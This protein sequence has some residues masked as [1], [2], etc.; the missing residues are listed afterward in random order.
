LA[1]VGLDNSK[2]EC[3]ELINVL[4]LEGS[5]LQLGPVS[6][7]DVGMYMRAADV[8]ILPSRCDGWGAVISE[9]A[10]LGKALIAYSMVGAAHHMVIPGKNGFRAVSGDAD[11]FAECLQRY[12]ADPNLADVHGH[13][14]LSIYDEY[15]PKKNGARFLATPNKWL[16]GQE[17]KCNSES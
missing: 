11:S 4:G 8:I 2:G 3:G 10:S 14:S 17:G 15:T 12:M 5:V 7:R 16:A 6:F 1:L 9:G 13:Q